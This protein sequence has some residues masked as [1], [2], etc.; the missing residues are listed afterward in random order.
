MYTHFIQF[1]FSFGGE[2]IEEVGKDIL[3]LLNIIC[4]FELP[5]YLRMTS[6]EEEG[7]GFCR[8]FKKK[9]MAIHLEKSEAL[10]FETAASYPY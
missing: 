4:S 3:W 8:V 6:Q 9:L 10:I 1:K 2:T 5:L 7:G